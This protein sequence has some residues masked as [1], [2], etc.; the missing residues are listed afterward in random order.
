M[1]CLFFASVA[2]PSDCFRTKSRVL[3]MLVSVC[4]GT[5]PLMLWCMM[6]DSVCISEDTCERGGPLPV[7]PI[8]IVNYRYSHPTQKS[9]KYR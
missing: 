8:R 3:L 6:R 7:L 9:F 5:L 1:S 4:A 2:A